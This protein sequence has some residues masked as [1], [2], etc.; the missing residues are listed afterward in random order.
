MNR[1]IGGMQV[2]TKEE[3][4]NALF[5]H[6]CPHQIMLIKWI[7]SCSIMTASI[8]PVKIFFANLSAFSRLFPMSPKRMAEWNHRGSATRW[9]FHSRTVNS[10]NE[11]IEELIECFL[12]IRNEVGWHLFFFLDLFHQIFPHAELLFPVFLQGI[13]VS[14]WWQMQWMRSMKLLEILSRLK[15]V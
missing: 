7:L 10:V 9:N 8:N 1:G 5:M 3:Y 6:C 14:F 13:Q 2:R 4:P 15:V 12:V 11:M